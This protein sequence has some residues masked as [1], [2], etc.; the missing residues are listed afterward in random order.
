[1]VILSYIEMSQDYEIEPILLDFCEK[2]KD[3]ANAIRTQ[4]EFTKLF[5]DFGITEQKW[6]KLEEILPYKDL[7]RHVSITSYCGDLQIFADTLIEKV[8][9]N[10]LD[11]S[12]QH[13]ETVTDI[14]I[15]CRNTDDG[16]IIIWNDNGK[17]IPAFEKEKIFERGFGR[18]TGL[19]L[20]LSRE[21]L[22]N[23]GITIKETGTP[24][25]GARFEM[26]VPKDGFRY[27]P[28]EGIKTVN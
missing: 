26:N 16:L 22:L 4:I 24:G 3:A 1:M 9:F 28:R 20:F 25:E 10:L 11:N 17:G 15:S 7:P 19:G 23:S 8:F 13:G 21:V 5:K 12:L 2:I 18:N 6:Q 27:G 14:K